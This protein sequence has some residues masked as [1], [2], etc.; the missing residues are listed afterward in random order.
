M[1]FPLAPGRGPAPSAACRPTT[2]AS[3]SGAARRWNPCSVPFPQAVYPRL[4]ITSVM[5]SAGALNAS[6]SARTAS[7]IS[8]AERCFTLR[9]LF[10]Q[11]VRKVAVV[12][13]FGD[14]VSIEQQNVARAEQRPL[15]HLVL[16]LEAERTLV[17]RAVDHVQRRLN[18]ERWRR[19]P[20]MG[21]D[22]DE[23]VD[24]RREDARKG[25]PGRKEPETLPPRREE[26]RNL[27][28]PDELYSRVFRF[29]NS[30]VVICPYRSSSYSAPSRNAW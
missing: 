17:G 30:R 16:V 3:G 22:V 21:L 9:S 28:V 12:G 19:H 26:T 24:T 20:P 23:S 1:S 25:L 7:H 2:G 13:M 14:T 4:T 11:S 8:R 29:S 18:A 6:M 27:C 10:F 5:S 15:V